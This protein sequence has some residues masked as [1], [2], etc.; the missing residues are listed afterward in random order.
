MAQK[1]RAGLQRLLQLNAMQWQ[2]V[3]GSM[4]SGID[5]SPRPEKTYIKFII[6][7][8]KPFNTTTNVQV[9]TYKVGSLQRNG[10]NSTLHDDQ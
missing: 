1:P 3:L 2:P 8:W 10:H 4:Q 7:E 9:V 6:L 5:V